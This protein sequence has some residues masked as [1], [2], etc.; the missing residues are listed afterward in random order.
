M[1]SPLIK[2][3]RS[4]VSLAANE[5]TEA[6]IT[7][8]PCTILPLALRNPSL[9]LSDRQRATTQFLRSAQNPESDMNRALVC[10]VPRSM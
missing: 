5:L 1:F 3:R 4:S 8:L 2:Y 10:T 7:K 9:E 6:T